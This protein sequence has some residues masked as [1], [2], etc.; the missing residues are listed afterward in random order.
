MAVV[1]AEGAYFHLTWMAAHCTRSPITIPW[2]PD[3]G[4]QGRIPALY[5]ERDL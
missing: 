3:L 1:T 5:A 2:D 4:G